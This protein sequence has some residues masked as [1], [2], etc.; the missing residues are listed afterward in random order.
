VKIKLTVL[1][2]KKPYDDSVI[3]SGGVALPAEVITNPEA[4]ENFWKNAMRGGNSGAGR[5]QSGQP[6]STSPS[7]AA[8]QPGASS[9]DNPRT[10]TPQ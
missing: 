1:K 8:T 4:F 10:V 5:P 2:S 6:A 3:Y 7:G 9:A